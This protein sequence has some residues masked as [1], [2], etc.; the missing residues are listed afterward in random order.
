MRPSALSPFA[1]FAGP[2]VT[3][4]IA[5]AVGSSSTAEPEIDVLTDAAEA[6][7]GAQNYPAVTQQQHQQP[8]LRHGG[9]GFSSS[10][11]AAAEPT[12]FAPQPLPSIQL[13]PQQYSTAPS[14]SRPRRV[15]TED[16]IHSQQQHHKYP[17]HNPQQPQQIVSSYAESLLQEVQVPEQVRLGTAVAADAAAA[18]AAIRPQRQAAP[19]RGSAGPPEGPFAMQ[20]PS[21]YTVPAA[22]E[23]DIAPSDASS[24][25]LLN[26]RGYGIYGTYGIYG[27][28]QQ[29]DATPHITSSKI[30]TYPP[31]RL[32]AAPRCITS[33]VQQMLEHHHL[34]LVAPTNI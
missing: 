10:L 33:H 27:G 17:Y 6:T 25:L 1:L 12:P 20:L 14:I 8:Q 23:V 15:S 19:T 16:Q 26:S 31:V 34:L 28:P 3:P 4:S 29:E 5:A 11:L 32:G 7:N 24:L 2:L 30:V 22:A 9:D 21:G 13:Q 18:P